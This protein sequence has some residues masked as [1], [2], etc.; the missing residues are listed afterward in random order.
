MVLIAK[1]RQWRFRFKGLM[2]VF[3]LLLLSLAGRLLYLQTIEA[4]VLKEKALTLHHSGR[5]LYNRGRIVDR[6]GVVLAQDSYQYDVYAHPETYRK[7]FPKWLQLNNKVIVNQLAAVLAP[8]LGQS[9]AH[10]TESLSTNYATQVLTKNGSLS[11]YKNLQQAVLTLPVLNPIDGTPVLDAT[12]QPKQEAIKLASILDIV[13]LNTR[14]YPQGS[15]AAHILGYVNDQAGVAAGLEENA[16]AYLRTTPVDM[17]RPERNSQG[18]VIDVETHP[19]ESLTQIPK[20]T[21]LQLTIDAYLQHVAEKE[22]AKGLIASKAERGTVIMLN[23]HTGEVLAYAVAPSFTPQTYYH[24]TEQQRTNWPI[25]EVYPPG[26]TMKI[27]TVASA[28][29][30]GVLSPTSLIEDTGRMKLGNWTIQNYDYARH[31]AP[32][33]I[34]LVY[35]FQHSSNIASAKVSLMMPKEA[36]RNLLQAFGYGKRTGIELPGESRGIFNGLET[37]DHTTH[38]TIGYGYGLAAT[39][40]QMAAAVSSIANNGV[41]ITPHLIKTVIPAFLEHSPTPTTLSGKPSPTTSLGLDVPPSSPNTA[42]AT[43]SEVVSPPV[44][45]IVQ[46]RVL[47]PK[48]CQ[49]M[50]DLLLASIERQKNATVKVTGVAVAGKTGTSRKPAT[51]GYS[52][53]VFTSFVGYFPARNPQVLMMVVVD[54]PKVAEAWG[55]TVAGPIFQRIATETVRYLGIPKQDDTVK[56]Q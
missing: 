16:K 40:L 24:S 9:V 12:G 1:E 22:L 32:G 46:R 47:S 37:W 8:I 51:K 49:A 38:A 15:L 53:N 2:V 18:Q 54:S 3:I 34:D 28:L 19:P 35:L 42:G 39:P 52:N 5:V 17:I 43:G 45:T 48:T 29:E 6:N 11:L 7:V 10:V 13:P 26:S 36:H 30:L 41:W 31:G 44:A 56:S 33:L 25:L 14:N 50:T 23:P 27:V 4:P 20:A 55:S 21:D